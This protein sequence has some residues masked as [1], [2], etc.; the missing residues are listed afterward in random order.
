MTTATVQG[1]VD[2]HAPSTRARQFFP[3]IVFALTFGLLLSD[4]MS[5]QV[6]SAVFPFLK[7]EWALSDAQLGSLTSVVALAVGLLAVPL[8]LLADRW[9]RVRAVVVMAA[10]WSVATAASAFAAGYGELMLSRLFIGV[11]EAAFGSVGLA[12]VLGVFPAYRRAAF[13]GAFMAGGSFGSVIGV[14]LGG[15]LAVQ[16]GWRWAFGAMAILGFVLVGLYRLLLSEAKLDRY[17]VADVAEGE[18]VGTTGRRARLRTLVNTPAVLCAYVGSGLQLFVAGSLF[19]W[20][21]SYVGRAYGLAPDKAAGVA[22]IAILL[23]GVGMIICGVVTDRLSRLVPIRKWTTAIVYSAASLVFLGL[24]FSLHPGAAQLLLL[25]IGVFFAAGTAGPAGAMVANLTVESIRA[26]A[27]GTLTLANNLLGLAAGPFVIGLLA[28]SVGLVTAM[29]FV[30][31]AA[32]A[33]IAFLYVG[34]LVYPMSLRMV[35]SGETAR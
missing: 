9:G 8:S 4:Y 7:A 2:G 21:P 23:M 1:V 22:A 3:W 15:V 32:L 29:R 35:R 17:R 30:P 26:T 19:A 11:G 25:A 33:S 27:L 28:D 12:V 5:R 18:P 16:F 20:L 6:L 34:R 13:T 24:G 10:V 31:L 14:A